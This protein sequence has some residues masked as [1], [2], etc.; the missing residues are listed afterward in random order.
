MDRISLVS[1]LV[2]ENE[3][4]YIQKTKNMVQSSLLC[5]FFFY[6]FIAILYLFRGV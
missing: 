1:F 4:E 2:Y 3:L 6:N 5:V